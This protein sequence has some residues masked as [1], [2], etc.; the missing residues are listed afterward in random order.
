MCF[1]SIPSFFINE[2][3]VYIFLED[4]ILET[5]NRVS[6]WKIHIFKQ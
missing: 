5:E 3:L 6:L 1:L 4:N 2:L